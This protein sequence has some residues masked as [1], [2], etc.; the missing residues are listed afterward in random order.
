MLCDR[1]VSTPESFFFSSVISECKEVHI[2][3]GRT[4]FAQSVK[5][6][7]LDQI[8]AVRT[9]LCRTLIKSTP[10]TFFSFQDVRFMSTIQWRLL[11]SLGCR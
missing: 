11:R 7:G 1:E 3:T 5:T 4:T 10:V 9:G 2:R 6:A 8:L